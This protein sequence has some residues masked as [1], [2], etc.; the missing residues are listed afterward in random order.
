MI[1]YNTINIDS[2]PFVLYVTHRNTILS[3]PIVYIYI[4]NII[5]IMMLTEINILRRVLI[6]VSG[7]VLGQYQLCIGTIC[8]LLRS[9]KM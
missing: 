8:G 9:Y 5:R 1:C 6:I 4:D 2:N 7:K 3:H